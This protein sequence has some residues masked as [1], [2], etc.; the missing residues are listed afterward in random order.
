MQKLKEDI[1]GTFA[2]SEDITLQAVGKMDYLKATIDE[3][4]RIFPVASYAQ[5]FTTDLSRHC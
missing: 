1:R 5:R 2:T 3:G 4:L